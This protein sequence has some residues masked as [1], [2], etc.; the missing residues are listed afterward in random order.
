MI[1]ATNIT[2]DY[3][4]ANISRVSALQLRLK[5]RLVQG[6]TYCTVLNHWTSFLWA[7][8]ATTHS[9]KAFVINTT[10]AIIYYNSYPKRFTIIPGITVHYYFFN[11]ELSMNGH[12][13]TESLLL[14]LALV[15]TR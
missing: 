11:I 2:G 3:M 14:V 4:L 15:R 5:P 10:L 13:I 7:G 9:A 8:G 12:H 1:V 6:S